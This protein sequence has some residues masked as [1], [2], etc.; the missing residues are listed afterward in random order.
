MGR[1]WT[2]ICIGIVCGITEMLLTHCARSITPSVEGCMC[3]HPTTT[4]SINRRSQ[5]EE[6]SHQEEPQKRHLLKVVNPQKYLNVK[7]NNT[8]MGERE[9]ERERD[10]EDEQRAQAGGN[11]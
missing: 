8:L 1:P 3:I 5:L 11:I 2:Y 4:E 9:R 7:Q 6:K 10:Y